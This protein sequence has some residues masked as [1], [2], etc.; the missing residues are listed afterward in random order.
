VVF[1]EEMGKNRKLVWFRV[2]PAR[3]NRYFVWCALIFW[4][5]N[6]YFGLEKQVYRRKVP[7]RLRTH[8]RGGQVIACDEDAPKRV[9]ELWIKQNQTP[10]IL[11]GS[12][13]T[14]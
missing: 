13:K 8:Q 3:T 4:Q 11:N 14:R 2:Y 9:L 10:M 6:F 12:E 5:F 1:V 7:A